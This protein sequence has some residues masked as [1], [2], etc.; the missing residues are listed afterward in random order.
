MTQSAPHCV[1]SRAGGGGAAAG[2][3]H[4]LV[5]RVLPVGAG[6][7]VPGYHGPVRVVPELRVAA[8]GAGEG[9]GA[10]GGGHRGPAGRHLHRAAQHRDVLHPQGRG[11][12]DGRVMARARPPSFAISF[13]IT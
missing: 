13:R 10:G 8:L 3:V 9:H 2:A 12:A 6:H 11:D 7:R 1:C 4:L 5:R